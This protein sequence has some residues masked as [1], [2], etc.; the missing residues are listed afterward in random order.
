[1]SMHVNLERVKNDICFF[2]F[3]FSFSCVDVRLSSTEKKGLCVYAID[4]TTY[5]RKIQKN[6]VN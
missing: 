4:S 1:M 6:V 3:Q 2:L 5:E